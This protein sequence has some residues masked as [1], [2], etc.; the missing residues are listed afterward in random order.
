MHSAIKII[1]LVYFNYDIL[2]LFYAITIS[3]VYYDTYYDFNILRHHYLNYDI[4]INNFILNY[5]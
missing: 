2:S 5:Y 3:I 1:I 4:I